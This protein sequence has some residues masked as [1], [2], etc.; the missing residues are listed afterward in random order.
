MSYLDSIGRDIHQVYA[1]TPIDRIEQEL[2]K[3]VEAKCK[4]SFKNG[5]EAARK[6]QSKPKGQGAKKS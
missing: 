2:V 5:L 3:Y 1:N 4:E 6:R